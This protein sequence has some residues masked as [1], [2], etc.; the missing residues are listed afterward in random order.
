[1]LQSVEH[2]ES[3]GNAGTLAARD[4]CNLCNA[5][6]KKGFVQGAANH[7][8]IYLSALV[9]DQ[10]EPSSGVCTDDSLEVAIDPER[11][12]FLGNTRDYL[13]IMMN[14]NGVLFHHWPERYGWC[15]PLPIDLG[16]EAKTAQGT[17]SWTAEMKIPLE[18]I[19]DGAT[20]A[21][22]TPWGLHIWYSK[23]GA[24][25]SAS[26]S[27]TFGMFHVLSRFGLMTFEE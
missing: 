14:A 7:A 18:V 24:R 12:S 11:R 1:M 9:L 6:H 26:W 25:Q 2:T 5:C 20:R 27:R 19:A 15:K 10:V 13:H 16:I 21:P 23:R 8:F 17:D 22:D 3:A 4:F